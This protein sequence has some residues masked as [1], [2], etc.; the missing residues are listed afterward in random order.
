MVTGKNHLIREEPIE[1]M[2]TA[3]VHVPGH[4]IKP[5]LQTIGKE[6]ND[7]RDA[8]QSIDIMARVSW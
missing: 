7:S 6:G 2:L 4:W 8:G 3:K 5:V 1:S